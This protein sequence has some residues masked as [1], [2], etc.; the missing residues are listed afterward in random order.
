MK[1]DPAVVPG[2]LWQ[3]AETAIAKSGALIST[4]CAGDLRD[5]L[6]G[7][8]A[9]LI[10]GADP[11]ESV[12]TGE[13]EAAVAR[14]VEL[15]VEEAESDRAS[16]TPVYHLTEAVDL[17]SEPVPVPFPGPLVLHEYTLARAKTRFCPCFPIC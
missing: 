11:G 13:T 16:S 8:A 12:E 6:E 15:M 9:R 17:G 7:A 10:Q 3:T 1:V 2:L 14:I 4:E 5:L